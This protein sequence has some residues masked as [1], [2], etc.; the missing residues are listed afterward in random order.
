MRFNSL[1]FRLV[2]LAAIWAIF[3]LPI[4]A[5]VLRY[6]Y[7]DSAERN[8]RIA[9]DSDLSLLVSNLAQAKKDKNG[10]LDFSKLP[11][12]EY[13]FPVSGWYWQVIN[14]TPAIGAQKVY[15][16]DSLLDADWLALPSNNGAKPDNKGVF[17][18]IIIGPE[19]ERL[20]AIERELE[21][22]KTN[23]NRVDKYSLMVTRNSSVIEADVNDFTWKL[24]WALFVL[25]IGLVIAPFVQVHLGL[26]PLKAI[27]SG[28][29]DIRSGKSVH[30]QG[31]L[32]VEIQPLQTELNALIVSNQEI[33]ERA[34]M[35]V[36]NLAHALKTP[37]SVIS[38]EA[39]A[40]EENFSEKVIEQSQIMRDQISH[41]LDRARMAARVNVIGTITDLEP[42]LLPLIRVIGKIYEERN[43]TITKEIDESLKFRG[44][45]QD[46]EEMVGNL[47]DNAGK[48]A[49]SKVKISAQL[50]QTSETEIDKM[51]IIIEDD[52]PGLSKQQMQQ[53]MKRGR[54][55][56]ESKPGSGL[57]LSIV[58]ELAHLYKGEFMLEESQIGGVKA[59]LILPCA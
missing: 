6:V 11:R 17:A 54:R 31:D 46:L 50:M 43:I 59:K 5:L 49:E 9:L 4:T 38:N 40:K 37:L 29:S 23:E 18:G 12:A 16:S 47:L 30:L 22:N 57:G 39:N 21:V 1:A 2:A 55:L 45:K 35:H 58:L 27:S 13:Q 28:L 8:F 24:S 3:V 41:Y 7:E 34:R 10:N 36:G 52:G 48:W 51:E 14:K 53:A 25:G 33:V 32:P 44:E 20:F 15:H 26:R 42:A 56:D 19:N